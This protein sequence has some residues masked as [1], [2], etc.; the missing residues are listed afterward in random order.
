MRVEP[1]SADL[2]RRKAAVTR[3]TDRHPSEPQTDVVV[4][5]IKL[6]QRPFS[7]PTLQVTAQRATARR[8]AGPTPFRRGGCPSKASKK[9]KNAGEIHRAAI[10]KGS[11]RFR[12]AA[13]A[14]TGRVT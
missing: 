1:L 4:E 12:L 6:C 11:G 3:S 9:L 13:E 10:S 7:A 14:L 8:S 5:Q 2:E